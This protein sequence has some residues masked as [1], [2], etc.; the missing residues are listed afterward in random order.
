MRR[1]VCVFCGSAAGTD[2]A[3]AAVA[4]ELGT[5][6]AATGRTLVYGGGRV[7]LMGEVA[8]AT[9]AAGGPVVGVIPESLALKEIA[10]ADAT[11]LIVVDTMHRRKQI[12]ADRADSF[13]A[14]PGGFG[15]LDELFEILTWAQLGIHAKPVALLDVNG[16]FTPLLTY[17]DSVVANGLLKPKHR[18]L[19]LAT[20]SVEEALAALDAW[21]PADTGTKWVTP[22]ER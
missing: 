21:Q 5:A 20:R 2:P 8:T 10:F 4:R 3:F 15:T 14:L 16:F 9:V 18:E 7:G 11:E 1:H 19:L 12:M 17:L 22:G 6:L 13:I